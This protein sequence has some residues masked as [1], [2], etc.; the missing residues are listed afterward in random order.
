MQQEWVAS[1]PPAETGESL[2][3][4]GAETPTGWRGL[5]LSCHLAASFLLRLPL[6]PLA[7]PIPPGAMTRAMWAFPLVG[8]AV[9]VS[10]AAVYA[11]FV[12]MGFTSLLAALLAIAVITG[13]TGGLHEDGLADMADGFGVIGPRFEKL[14][15]MRESHIGTFGVL[16]LGFAMAM[17]TAAI[18]A[19]GETGILS[20]AVALIL[21]ESIG[22]AAMPLAIWLAPP[23][24]PDGLGAAASAAKDHE[25]FLSMSVSVTMVS[26]LSL[27]FLLPLQA[28]AIMTTM[29]LIVR[30]MVSCACKHIGGHT[31]DVL[32]A[33]GHAVSTA[34]LMSLTVCLE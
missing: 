31:G 10:G 24:R 20:V 14:A 22:R 16:A 23:A 1:S 30:T 19:V 33:T 11:V 5:I 12:L 6:P 26:I 2:V 3:C 25:T 28:M 8:I 15:V 4:G 9:G 27:I 29:I 32:G 13:L 7:R 21:A 17:R 18:T 34:V